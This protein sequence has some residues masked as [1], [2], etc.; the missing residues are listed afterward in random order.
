MLY[1]RI[2][3]AWK[4]RDAIGYMERADLTGHGITYD[5]L[6]EALSEAGGIIDIEGCYPINDAIRRKLRKFLNPK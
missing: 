1:G 3:L 5:M 6:E 4:D 2:R